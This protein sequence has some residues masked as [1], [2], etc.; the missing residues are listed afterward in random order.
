MADSFWTMVFS[1]ISTVQMSDHT[2]ACVVA[3]VTKSLAGVAVAE[4]VTPARQE[5]VNI[6]NHVKERGQSECRET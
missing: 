6:I 4:V 2:L 5:D 1:L 3:K